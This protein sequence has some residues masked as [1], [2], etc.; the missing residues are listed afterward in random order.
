MQDEIPGP[1]EATSSTS[2][3]GTSLEAAEKLTNL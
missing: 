2:G 1:E 3:N